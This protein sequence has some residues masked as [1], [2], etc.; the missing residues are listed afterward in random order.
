MNRTRTSRLPTPVSILLLATYCGG[1]IAENL[2]PNPDF[3]TNLD[4][5]TIVLPSDTTLDNSTGSPAAPS[6]RMIAVDGTPAA[7]A[8]TD[9]LE[10][11]TSSNVDLIVD[12]RSVTGT[13][14]ASATAYS[15]AGCLG[16]IGPAG[17]VSGG[18]PLVD[19]WERG[20]AIDYALP[21]G[22]VGVRV[23]LSVNGDLAEANFDRVR[24]G[25]T[26]TTP[27]S[28]QSFRID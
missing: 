6:M 1:A 26:G 17:E 15:G 19:G 4:G 5:W 22:T 13:A 25:P 24:F 14:R 23:F 21:P 20:A 28:L 16:P 18:D 11:D 10:I 7:T 12:I 3:D 8:Y 9:C 2:V 27:V